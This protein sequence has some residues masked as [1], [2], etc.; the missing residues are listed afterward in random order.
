MKLIYLALFLLATTGQSTQATGGKPISPTAEEIT[1]DH[2]FVPDGITANEDAVLVASGW[3]PSPCYHSARAEI[4]KQGS[5]ITVVVKAIKDTT[6]ENCIMLAIPYLVDVRLGMLSAGTYTVKYGSA[7][8]R[9]ESVLTIDPAYSIRSN[10]LYA[11]VEFVRFDDA[12]GQLTLSGRN[13]SDCVELERVN[14]TS[15]GADTY[16]IWPIMRQ[17]AGECPKRLVPFE[18]N[19][20]I[21]ESMSSE[22][23]LYRVRILGGKSRFIN[24]LKSANNN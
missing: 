22:R 12:T 8:F 2:L 20:S 24:L 15:N 18:Y 5:T 19:V 11:R 6:P 16:T 23:V 9:A 4:S 13:P 10:P 14:V 1:I 21:P 7:D 3:L 17:V